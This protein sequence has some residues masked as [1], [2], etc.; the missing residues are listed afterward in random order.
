MQVMTVYSSTTSVKNSKWFVT[1]INR[2]G[3]KLVATERLISSRLNQPTINWPDVPH[4]LLGQI[5]PCEFNFVVF[6]FECLIFISIHIWL[7]C[8]LPIMHV[9]SFLLC[10]QVSWS[11]TT[12][13]FLLQKLFGYRINF[14]FIQNRVNSHFF[15]SKIIISPLFVLEVRI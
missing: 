3:I 11:N 1:S 6:L 2:N 14:P 8:I 5:I 4:L 10:T 9:F 7:E 12:V 13:L 15:I